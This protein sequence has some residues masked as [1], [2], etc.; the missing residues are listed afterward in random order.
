[1]VEEDFITLYFRCGYRLLETPS[2][3]KAEFRGLRRTAFGLV[4]LPLHR[5]GQT[6]MSSVS[7]ALIHMCTK[8]EHCPPAVGELVA[9]AYTE[10]KISALGTEIAGYITRN[11][12]LFPEER[13]EN[14]CTSLPTAAPASFPPL[15]LRAVS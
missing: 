10:Y 7:T 6:M 14:P 8:Y 11:N 15:A 2:I 5:Y 3:A 4:A 9:T 1:M 12:N 13:K